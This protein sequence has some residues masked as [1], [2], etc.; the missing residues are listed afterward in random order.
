MPAQPP[1]VQV[2]IHIGTLSKAFGAMGGFVAT[3]HT[4][5]ALV[6]N[7]VNMVIALS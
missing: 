7:K 4:I 1:R 5:K 6:L 2:D 3:S